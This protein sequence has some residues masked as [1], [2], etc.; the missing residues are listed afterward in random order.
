MVNMRLQV[1]YKVLFINYRETCVAG[2]S[3]VRAAGN[4]HRLRCNWEAALRHQVKTNPQLNLSYVETGIGIFGREIDVEVSL[5][6][7]VPS[8]RV[9]SLC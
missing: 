6:N 3:R 7:G 9:S 8:L 4:A 1:Q 2:Y 5:S